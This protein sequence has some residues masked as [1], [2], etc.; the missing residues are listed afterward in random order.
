MQPN[1]DSIINLSN[2]T[3]ITKFPNNTAVFLAYPGNFFIAYDYDESTGDFS[4]LYQTSNLSYAL[5]KAD[6]DILEDSVVR[7]NR[8]DL[9]HALE[10]QGIT[11]SEENIDELARCALNMKGWRD[12]VTSEGNEYLADV[13]SLMAEG[14]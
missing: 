4:T 1:K 13:A 9:A 6:P 14:E 12:V 8:E 11:P 10:E 5:D 7:W 3:L 2:C